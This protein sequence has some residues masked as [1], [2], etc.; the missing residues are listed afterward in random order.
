MSNFAY[1]A[2]NKITVD[3]DPWFDQ[4]FRF[5]C[6]HLF[7]NLGG[8]MAWGEIIMEYEFNAPAGFETLR[9]RDVETYGQLT[10]LVENNLVQRGTIPVCVYK[11]WHDVVNQTVT[12]RFWCI[13]NGAFMTEKRKLLWGPNI[14]LMDIIK[15]LTP[16]TLLP[17]PLCYKPLNP[18]I[19]DVSNELELK[20]H[21][22]NI[23]DHE[24]LN[25]IL[26]GYRHNL[27]FG[28]AW[29]TLLMKKT[30]STDSHHND[31]IKLVARDRIEFTQIDPHMKEYRPSIYNPP[32]EIWSKEF[33]G[34]EEYA[35]KHPVN[36]YIW[37][38]YEEENV[39]ERKY[40]TLHSNVMY[41][42]MMIESNMV[43]NL[44]LI[45]DETI[46][47]YYLGDCLFYDRQGQFQSIDVAEPSNANRWIVRSNELF[48]SI[49]GSPFVHELN[50]KNF[51]FVSKL[52]M[53]EDSQSSIGGTDPFK[54]Q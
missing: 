24:F 13:P 40:Q 15:A 49:D 30:I 54:V 3:F 29:D 4:G 16:T 12:L 11:R 34:N 28:Y 36:P 22:N 10:I 48:F 2:P 20:Y 38:Q 8:E 53:L 50:G 26:F 1:K 41:N 33:V 19:T 21:Q 17:R 23:T 35:T 31:E 27:V 14:A 7:E 6:L 47:D 42:K 39:V 32:L 25:N 9:F 51:A 43:R 45:N 52:L 5:V 18:L 37:R 44:R 46:P